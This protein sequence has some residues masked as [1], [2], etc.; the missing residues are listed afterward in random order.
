MKFIYLY[1]SKY[2]NNKN[3]KNKNN[4]KITKNRIRKSETL[5]KTN[6][7]NSKHDNSNIRTKKQQQ[8]NNNKNNN[9]ATYLHKT[10]KYKFKNKITTIILKNQIFN[11]LSTTYL[12]SEVKNKKK[13]YVNIII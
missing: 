11:H 8:F 5:S 6:K 10:K 9:L 4:N 3:N 7:K 1:P 2:N 13:Y 12:M